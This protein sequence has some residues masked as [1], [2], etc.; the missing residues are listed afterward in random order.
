MPENSIADLINPAETVEKAITSRRSIRRFLPDPVDRQTVERLLAVASQAPRA[1]I[2]MQWT[3]RKR[4][5]FTQGVVF[6][7]I[8]FFCLPY[9][10]MAVLFP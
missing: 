8:I 5:P 1:M 6:G 3:P 2:I 7:S 9:L 10:F 4:M